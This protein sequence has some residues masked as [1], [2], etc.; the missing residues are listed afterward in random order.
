[1]SASRRRDPQSALRMPTSI[2]GDIA[3][4]MPGDL[5]PIRRIAD[6]WIEVVG[7]G[8]ARVAQPAR[9]ARDGTLI[10]HA[11]DASWVHALTLEQR[12]ILRKLGER[13]A[14][15]GPPAIKVEIGPISVA[16]EVAEDP[17]IVIQ[18]A[19]QARADELTS[20]VRDP[21]LKAA[22]NRAIATTL[23]RPNSP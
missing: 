5:G 7:E 10:V 22:L 20:E 23:S 12:T 3:N 21:R 9:L 1:M 19:A 14:G 16:P 8:L 2:G 17:P 6:V 13:M 18:P 4:S 15:D 11:V